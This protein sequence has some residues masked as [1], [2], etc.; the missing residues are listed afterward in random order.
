MI[1]TPNMK[2]SHIIAVLNICKR[3]DVVFLRK[4]ISSNCNFDEVKDRKG[5]NALHYCAETDDGPS[6]QA[7]PGGRLACAEIL[8][9]SE[10]KLQNQPDN[11]GYLPFHHAVIHGNIPLA[12]LLLAHGVDVNTLVGPPTTNEAM[13]KEG[14]ITIAGRSALHL[15]VI[16]ANYEMLEFLLSGSF[17]DAKGTTHKFTVNVDVQDA[18]SATALHYAVQLPE[19][20][21]T[22]I[23]KCIVERSHM[24][25]NCVDARGRTSLIWAATIGASLSTSILLELG[26]D[27]CKAEKSGLTALHCASSRGHTSTVQTIIKYLDGS[28][29][30]KEERG[31]ILD[32]QDS[33]G[34]PPLF[35]SITMGH[36][37]VTKKLLDA[38]ADPKV[39]DSRG[40]GPFHY[41]SRTATNA[42]A[43]VI[44][45]LL[46]YG[47]DPTNVNVVDDTAL[48]EACANSNKEC[49]TRLLKI[50]AIASS[51]I[52]KKNASSQ[53]PLQIATY[54]ALR[55]KEQAPS[56]NTAVEIC[57]L[58]VEAGANVGA[59]D[60]TET[61]PLSM[62]RSCLRNAPNYRPALELERIFNGAATKKRTTADSK[63]S[64]SQET[65]KTT[66]SSRDTSEVS[67]L[68]L[69]RSTY[70][71]EGVCKSTSEYIDTILPEEKIQD[72]SSSIRSSERSKS[73]KDTSERRPPDGFGETIISNVSQAENSCATT[74]SREDHSEKPLCHGSSSDL[75]SQ[76]SSV[77][78]TRGSRFNSSVSNR[79]RLESLQST[80]RPVSQPTKHSISTRKRSTSQPTNDDQPSTQVTN[81]KRPTSQCTEPISFDS[82]VSI[83]A[84]GKERETLSKSANSKGSR[85]LVESE[86]ALTSKTSK[87]TQSQRAPPLK[88]SRRQSRQN[89]IDSTKEPSKLPPHRGADDSSAAI[90]TQ[91]RRSSSCQ[92]QERVKRVLSPAVPLGSAPLKAQYQPAW[93]Q[94]S[95]ELAH[96]IRRARPT[97]SSDRINEL[98]KPRRRP[99]SCDLQ[100]KITDLEA[101]QKLPQPTITPY[102]M[103]VSRWPKTMASML[104]MGEVSPLYC[105]QTLNVAGQ[106]KLKKRIPNGV[107][108]KNVAKERVRSAMEARVQLSMA[109]KDF[110]KLAAQVLDQYDTLLIERQRLA[111][112]RTTQQVGDKY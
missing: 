58:L 14:N 9:E 21:S 57:H 76:T 86:K 98:A 84:N 4:L 29:M 105:A 44:D 69:D 11:D 66:E 46:E 81:S 110:V 77:S 68:S 33:D 104:L 50:D 60:D 100:R 17:E 1:S 16:Y 91:T 62:V 47:A 39:T 5:R 36:F 53:T 3:G 31:R 78:M 82:T 111:R 65:T 41:T 59:D 6:G 12:K 97:P 35:Y 26:A 45:L 10:F 22:S 72:R 90:V 49:V 25:I 79:T 34:C 18:Q 43:D 88:G 24:D 93:T 56:P 71:S 15:A 67:S 42:V 94:T 63:T 95:L 32:A 54:Q 92:P 96:C 103:P 109:E 37:D 52:N 20:I 64:E 99:R 7:K 8:L 108:S 73:D 89:T 80:S 87:P 40:R 30:N 70:G 106:S 51:L 74:K 75:P 101:K 55:T 2:A 38:G 19:G 112:T 13:E 85:T 48:H 61:S 23:I 27:P 28:Q 107:A 102:L 83:T